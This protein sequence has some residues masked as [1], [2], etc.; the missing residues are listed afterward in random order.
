MPWS[1]PV[2][3]QSPSLLRHPPFLIGV[4]AFVVLLLGG[5]VVIVWLRNWRE[6]TRAG[7]RSPEQEREHYRTL[8]EQGELSQEEYDTIVR[9]LAVPAAAVEPPK[10]PS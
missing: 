3:A 1:S 9:T 10:P 4:A 2:L 8:L 6:Q 5:L 7:C